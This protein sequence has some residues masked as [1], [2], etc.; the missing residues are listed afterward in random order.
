MTA[1]NDPKIGV[2]YIRR[3]ISRTHTRKTLCEKKRKIG[4]YH[5]CDIHEFEPFLHVSK[6]ILPWFHDAVLRHSPFK[7]FLMSFLVFSYFTQ[8][9]FSYSYNSRNFRVSL[10]FHVKSYADFIS[11]AEFPSDF[12]VILPIKWYFRT[13]F[14]TESILRTR[15]PVFLNEWVSGQHSWT[16]NLNEYGRS[17]IFICIHH[18]LFLEFISRVCCFPWLRTQTNRAGSNDWN[19][20]STAHLITLIINSLLK[21]RTR[22]PLSENGILSSTSA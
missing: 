19:L 21:D 10:R 5:F 18:P 16:L 9:V 22:Q 7:V 20:L 17:W 2:P 13:R 1:Q 3:L 14:L 15:R 12:N 6:S 4:F 11:S 8:A